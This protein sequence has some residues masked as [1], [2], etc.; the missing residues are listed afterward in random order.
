[1][2]AG[3]CDISGRIFEGRVVHD[4]MKDFVGNFAYNILLARENGD[5]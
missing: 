1:V 4:D 5:H 3:S 2:P